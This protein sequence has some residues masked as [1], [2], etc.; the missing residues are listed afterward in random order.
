[1][2]VQCGVLCMNAASRPGRRPFQFDFSRYRTP[3]LPRCYHCPVL[4]SSARRHWPA[5][6]GGPALLPA[7]HTQHLLRV[8]SPTS[9]SLATIV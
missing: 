4:C 2:L 5:I 6:S 9:P 7:S 8:P 1:M 3:L